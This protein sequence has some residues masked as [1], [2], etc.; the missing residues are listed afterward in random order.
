[1]ELPL[2]SIM[3]KTKKRKANPFEKYGFDTK[4]KTESEPNIELSCPVTPFQNS[5]IGSSKIGNTIADQAQLSASLYQFC[6][7][8]D[9]ADFLSHKLVFDEY[10]TTLENLWYSESSFKFPPS[11]R[12][13]KF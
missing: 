5:S 6:D 13:L 2:L 3:E 9:I 7:K 11:K 12:N 10:L 1:M 4:K 8:Y